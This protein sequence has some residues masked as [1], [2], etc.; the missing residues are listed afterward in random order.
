MWTLSAGNYNS[1]TKVNW[2]SAALCVC[3]CSLSKLLCTLLWHNTQNGICNILGVKVNSYYQSL[4]DS[5]LFVLWSDTGPKMGSL[6]SIP[7]KSIGPGFCCSREVTLG[8][9]TPRTPC[10]LVLSVLLCVNVKYDV[11]STKSQWLNPPEKPWNLHSSR[12]TWLFFF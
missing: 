12:T 10:G 7:Q 5:L 6:R 8:K 1:W 11:S 3:D 2:G 9:S 4:A